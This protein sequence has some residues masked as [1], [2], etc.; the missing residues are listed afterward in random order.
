M[1]LS[2][3]ARFWLPVVGLLIIAAYSS[4]SM[5][6]AHFI[7]DLDRLPQ[8]DYYKKIPPIRGGIYCSPLGRAPHPIVKSMPCWEYR[9]DPVAITQSVVRIRGTKKIRTPRAQA[10]TIADVL[11]LPR[12]EVY[13]M[14]NKTKGPGFRNQF[15]A[16]SD[17]RRIYD[18]LSDR[19]IV[20][21]I[22][23]EETYQRR[24]FESNRLCHVVRGV[25]EKYNTLLR[26]MPGEIR[27][28]QDANRILI[29]DK[30]DVNTPAKPGVDVYLTVDHFL[31]KIVEDELK[32]GIVEFGAGAGWCVILDVKTGRVLSMASYPD[33]DIEGKYDKDNP[34]LANR[35]LNYMYE[36]GSVMKVITA[37]A[38]IDAGF[39]RPE[40]VYTTNRDEK[41][42][43]G[44]NKYARLPRDSH[45]LPPKITLRDAI[46]ES[47][48]IVIGKL[49][50]DFGPKR[51]YEYIK[52]FGFGERVGIELPGE[53][54]GILHHYS[55]WDR[56]TW[57][58]A[59]IGQGVAVTALQMASAYQAIANGG[60]RKKPYII[61][62]I[63]DADGNNLHV[64]NEDPG[65]RVISPSAAYS[66]RN[67]MLGVATKEGT[68]RRAKV[69]GYS[70]AGKTGTAQ[71]SKPKGQGK[72]YAEGLYIAT[73]CGIVPSG[74]EKRYPDDAQ[75]VPPEV[76][77]L[78]S[79]DFD[80][81]RLYHAGGNSA[82]PVFKRIA[83]K[84]M[85]YLEI[86]PDRLNELE[87][88]DI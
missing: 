24:Y 45:A 34:A 13:S 49:G 6:K 77:I 80:E 88:E 83:E 22:K 73:F 65:E 40:T 74:V 53:K 64:R 79:L 76:V 8:Y 46:V 38:A 69:K 15:L 9:F 51:V 35:V 18:I 16:V 71:K 66:T 72:G 56:L 39:A 68:A 2:K 86:S 31:Q 3:N 62:R 85:R 19:H 48:N 21:G 41:N 4:Y 82:G 78:V 44:E 28:K 37:A 25:N 33:F 42:A 52:K 81:K 36:P 11:K 63:I 7:I 55:K 30:I 70:V 27:G 26:G 47:S 20:S 5:I 60:I 29:K 54:P 84:A 32:S 87:D 50:Y 43:R 59:P 75:C 23:I 58:R 67:M 61:D 14:M 1:R 10:K 57:S 12:D 17:D